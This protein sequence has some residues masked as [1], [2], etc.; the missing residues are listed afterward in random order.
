MCDILNCDLEPQKL[1]SKMKRPVGQMHYSSESYDQ[2]HQVYQKMT[3]V[4][5]SYLLGAKQIV[6]EAKQIA[7][8]DIA[9]KGNNGVLTVIESQ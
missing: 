8:H 3:I 2:S 9:K 7:A 6:R 1:L 4:H 5:L